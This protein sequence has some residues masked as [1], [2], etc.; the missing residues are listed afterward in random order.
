MGLASAREGPLA[1]TLLQL[2]RPPPPGFPG[3]PAP[4]TLIPWHVI[5]NDQLPNTSQEDETG[6]SSYFAHSKGVLVIDDDD[7]DDHD[8]SDSGGGFFLSHSAPRFPD[9]PGQN[10]G[11]SGLLRPQQRFSQHFLCVSLGSSGMEN[12]TRYLSRAFRPRAFSVALPA[13]RRSRSLE[14]AAAFAAGALP[15]APTSSAEVRTA[16][17]K[18]LLLVATAGGPSS[19]PLWDTVVASALGDAF[20]V[21]TSSSSPSS[22]AAA[23]PPRLL[24]I[25]PLAVQSWIRTEGAAPPKCRMPLSGDASEF[26]PFLLPSVLGIRRVSFGR[27][28]SGDSWSSQE[29]H[30]KFGV[31]LGGGREDDDPLLSFSC[32]GDTNRDA[33][34]RAG[35]AACVRWPGL[36]RLLASG[37]EEVDACADERLARE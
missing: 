14:A 30:A 8:D 1:R 6:P 33:P 32:V 16:K 27:N 24:L 31:A 37:V 35:G 4:S 9:D 20:A 17:G 18:E 13:R 5:W 23:P 2:Y 21:A 10:R 29:A 22:G 12:L 3:P 25:P 26:S 11:Y 19:S 28:S 36:R 15:L 7:D 34:W